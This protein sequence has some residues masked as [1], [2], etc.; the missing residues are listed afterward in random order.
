MNKNYKIHKYVLNSF[1]ESQIIEISGLD[2][3]LSVG[4]DPSEEL[5]IWAIVDTNNSNVTWTRVL[6]IGTG[7]SFDPDIL[8]DTELGP[9]N[10]FLGSVTQGSF[11]W[12]VFVSP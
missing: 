7:I 9:V 10:R 4:L 12:H 3:I 5:C 1:L 8:T 6:I 2:R 11:V